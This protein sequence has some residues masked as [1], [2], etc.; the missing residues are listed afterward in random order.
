MRGRII[1]IWPHRNDSKWIDRSMAS[2]LMQLYM[3]HVHCATNAK[4]LEDAFNIIEEVWVFPQQ[5]H[6][7]LKVNNL[8]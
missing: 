1:D 8:Q 7:A 5:L 3:F 2:I 4:D 6:V